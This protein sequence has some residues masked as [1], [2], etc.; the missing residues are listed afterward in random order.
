[1]SKLILVML[2]LSYDLLFSVYFQF[3]F[4]SL[5]TFSLIKGQR[6]CVLKDN[7]VILYPTGGF[8][9]WEM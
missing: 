9:E 6:I 8:G 4:S 5:N 1:M 2:I 3:I 7:W